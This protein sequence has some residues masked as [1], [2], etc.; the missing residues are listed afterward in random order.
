[1]LF[2]KGIDLS[3]EPEG[4]NPRLAPE[5]ES[6]DL[7]DFD[8]F[9]LD[10]FR[11]NLLPL[12][13][14]SPLFPVDVHGFDAFERNIHGT[15]DRRARWSQDAHDREG[16][17]LVV[18]DTLTAG[19]AVSDNNPLTEPVTEPLCHF[20]AKR[21]IEYIRRRAAL[22]ELY[23]P[24][25]PVAVLTV[26]VFVRTHHPIAA[27]AVSQGNRNGPEDGRLVFDLLVG[28]VTHVG[29]R[30]AHMKDRVEKQLK[31]PAAS[32]HNEVRLADRVGKTLPR[33]RRVYAQ[34]PPRGSHLE[35]KTARLEPR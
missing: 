5:K 25:L 4:L 28:L 17:V 31:R 2:R 35:P 16:L 23:A 8:L 24:V 18:Q 13:W 30:R 27:M 11:R 15:I 7:L 6:R 10:S 22:L 26:E 3:L 14:R 21:D 33:C 32:A 12:E 34:S 1:R 19:N 29:R 20:A 9:L